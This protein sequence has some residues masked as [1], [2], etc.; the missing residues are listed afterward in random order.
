MKIINTKILFLILACLIIV[1]SIT[2]YFHNE[3]EAEKKEKA[4]QEKFLFEKS[5]IDFKSIYG[6][7]KEK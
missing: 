3:K 2:I 4:A 7:E 6:S 5:G 1:T